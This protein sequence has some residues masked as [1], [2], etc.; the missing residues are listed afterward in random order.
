M[1]IFKAF[2]FFFSDI[3]GT[4]SSRKRSPIFGQHRRPKLASGFGFPHIVG[5]T[6]FQTSRKQQHS[7]TSPICSVLLYPIP[8]R[9]RLRH[10][11]EPMESDRDGA[12]YESLASV[13]EVAIA[14]FTTVNST[15]TCLVE[16]KGSR[17]LGESR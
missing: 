13:L 17:C 2:F 16:D 14:A 8:P 12:D 15:T 4:A 11:H 1:L 6:N 10:H 3:F 9:A 7:S 5:G